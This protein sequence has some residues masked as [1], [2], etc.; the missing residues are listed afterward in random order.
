MIDTYPYR[1]S[2]PANCPRCGEESKDTSELFFQGTHV[3]AEHSC[4]DCGLD[5]YSTLPI[6]HAALYPVVC[7]RDGSYARYNRQ[8]GSWMALPLIRSFQ[9][10]MRMLGQR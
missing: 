9:K 4:G 8:E 5:F 10:K 6:G 3:L 1:A 2:I 7:A